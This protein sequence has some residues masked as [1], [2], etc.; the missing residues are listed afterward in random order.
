MRLA[1]EYLMIVEEHPMK[2]VFEI[3]SAALFGG[4]LMFTAV[5]AANA[6]T[7]LGTET[8]GGGFVGPLFGPGTSTLYN[9]ASDGESGFDPFGS[10]YDTSD[11]IQLPTTFA[12]TQDP[13]TN[14]WTS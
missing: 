7:V 5:P 4:L 12:W 11:G 1:T 13:D 2:R 6:Y 3:A 9:V 14:L 8:S 10:G